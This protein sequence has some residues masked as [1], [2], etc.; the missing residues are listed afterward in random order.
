MN[1]EQLMKEAREVKPQAPR[2]EVT[3]QGNIDVIDHPAVPGVKMIVLLH[4]PSETAY[5]IPLA[6]PMCRVV[7]NKLT[8]GAHV[9]GQL[10]D[11]P[12]G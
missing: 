10:E 9:D 2:V 3:L 6:A 12:T 11:R 8:R 1:I 7:A 4:E 5:L